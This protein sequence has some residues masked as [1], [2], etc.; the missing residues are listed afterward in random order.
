MAKATAKQSIQVS[1]YLGLKSEPSV[2]APEGASQTFKKGAPV[3]VS[4]GQAVV[5]VESDVTGIIGIAAHDASGVQ[6]D[7]VKIVPAMPG[8]VFQAELSDTTDGKYTSQA[9][10]LYADFGLQVTTD[11]KWFVDNDEAGAEQVVTVIGFID[12]VGTENARV[13]FVFKNSVTIFN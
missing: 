9:G 10:D 13:E 5:L 6:G 4:A 2:H 8:V 3:K 1:R 12:P 11:G 7:D